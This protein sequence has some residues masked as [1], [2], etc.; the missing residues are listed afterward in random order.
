MAQR[1]FTPGSLERER[2]KQRILRVSM[3]LFLIAA[4]LP[5][6][7]GYLWL[8]VGAFTGNLVYGLVPQSFTVENWSFLWDPP[9]PAWPDI[10]RTFFNTFFLAAGV[11]LIMVV[12][13]TSAAYVVS[14]MYFPGRSMILASTLILHAFPAITLLIALYYILRTLGLLD[15][16]WGVI[17]VR[18]GLMVPFGIWV[19]K[20]FFDDIPW[21][22]EMSALIDGATR[23]QTFWKVMLPLV[24]PGI[25]AIAVFAF[26]AGWAEYIFLVTFVRDPNS[27]TL[28]SYINAI[29]G[30]YRFTNYGLLAAVSLFYMFPVLLFFLL[31]QKLLMK[32]T[33]GG[34]KGGR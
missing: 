33:V 24:K 18:A 27:W 14:R 21:D 16:L 15:S 29:I 4:S 32:V 19:M 28:S 9:S 11:T 2:R 25:A 3:Y 23:F 1:K 30:N 10:W 12:V 6:V 7:I 34:I 8:F 26:M 5:I 31:T 22:I 13:S 17:L 20:G